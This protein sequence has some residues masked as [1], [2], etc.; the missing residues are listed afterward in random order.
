MLDFLEK[1]P[2]AW[3]F[4]GVVIAACI[5]FAGQLIAAALGKKGG[6]PEISQSQ[7]SGSHSNN[8]QI[9]KIDNGTDDQSK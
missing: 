7:R 9:G 5:A 8:V 6:K 4:I 3:G 1:H 2:Y